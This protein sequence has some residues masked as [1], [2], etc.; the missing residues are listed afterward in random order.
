MA[1]YS[2]SSGNFTS[3]TVY[4]IDMLLS[5]VARFQVFWCVVPQQLELIVL[6][7]IRAWI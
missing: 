4:I 7:W 2:T 3:F 6:K 5:V 1:L